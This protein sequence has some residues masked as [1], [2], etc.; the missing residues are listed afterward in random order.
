MNTLKKELKE[1]VE[2]A[3]AAGRRSECTAEEHV[4]EG[5]GWGSW[6]VLF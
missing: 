3:G 1:A 6:T 2:K 4:Q 5:F